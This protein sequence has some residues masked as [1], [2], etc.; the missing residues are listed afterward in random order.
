[1]CIAQWTGLEHREKVHEKIQ[2]KVQFFYWDKSTESEMEKWWS[3]STKRQR[4]KEDLWLMR[5]ESPMKEQVV[6]IESIHKEEF[7]LQS[8]ATWEQS[9]EQKATKAELPKHGSMSEEVCVF[10]LCTSGTQKAGFRGMNLAG[11]SSEASGKPD[12]RG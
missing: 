10:F 12:I 4:K 11:N 5:Q 6:R 2:R 3:S 7:L 8:T 1:M 9:L